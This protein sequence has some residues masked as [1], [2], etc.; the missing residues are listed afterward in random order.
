MSKFRT[1]LFAVAACLF[2]TVAYAQCDGGVCRLKP[3]QDTP[4][5]IEPVIIEQSAT[6]PSTRAAARVR[7][8]GGCGSGS[9]CGFHRGGS[10]I[11]TNAHVAGTRVGRQCAVDVV[12]NGKTKTLSGRVIM[13]AYSDRTLTDWAIVHVEDWQEIQ[14][15]PLSRE[16]PTGS[17]YTRGSPRCIWPQRST[18]V[19]TVDVSDN[20]PLWRWMPNSIGGQSGS[21]VWSDR[22]NLQYG[23]LTWSWGGRGAGQT[24]AQIWRQAREK[25]T[26]GPVRIKGLIEVGDRPEGLIVE[27]GFFSQAGID[28]F[29]I[30]QNDNPQPP[31]S[32]KDPSCPV[33]PDAPACDVTA[34]EL[35]LIYSL[36]Q[37]ADD[38]REAIRSVLMGI[39]EIAR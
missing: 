33:C 17:H 13:A 4:D 20:S 27:N 35:E 12:V 34:K 15:V 29:D 1:V 2:A 8:S 39:I 16:Y 31:D 22:D 10:L 11:L 3:K 32:P 18:D 6:G 24:T 23:L 19:R 28:E 37:A 38:E 5:I 21:G 36:R 30:W 26:S 9:V 25:S 7:V 14:P